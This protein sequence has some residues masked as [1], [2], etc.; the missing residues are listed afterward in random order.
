MTKEL[1]RRGQLASGQQQEQELMGLCSMKLR[2]SLAV[3]HVSGPSPRWQ[4]DVR[5][6]VTIHTMKP[7]S[8]I[9]YDSTVLSSWRIL[10]V[11]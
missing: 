9:L 10:P 7:F 5:T 2:L 3:T 1:E 6:L 11:L 8:S 4:T